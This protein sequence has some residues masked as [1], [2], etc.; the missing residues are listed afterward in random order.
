MPPRNRRQSAAR[1]EAS[2]RKHLPKAREYW[3]KW[4]AY[5][6]EGD[7]CQAGE[8]GWGA[9]AQ[10]AKA[11]ASHRGWFHSSHEAI[12]SAIRQIADES[13]TPAD[14]RRALMHAE[15]LHGNFYEINLDQIDT[16]LGLEDARGLLEVLWRQLPGEFTGGIPF[17]EW[18]SANG[19]S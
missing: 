9:V 2:I 11:V 7:L 5:L 14:I 13:D 15:M 10:L 6:A 4:P 8:K 16:G 17:D 3:S 18:A 1:R 19:D 12:R